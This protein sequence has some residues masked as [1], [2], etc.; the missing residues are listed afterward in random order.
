M[1]A[2]KAIVF[3]LGL[4]VPCAALAAPVEGRL[5]TGGAPLTWE[6]LTERALE[7]RIVYVGEEH[8]NRSHHL[9]QRDLL[10]VLADAGPVVLGVEYF[11]R[12][13]QPVLDRFHRGEIPLD[14]FPR[15]VDWKKTWGHAWDAY[16]PL[17]RL[18]HERKIRIVALNSKREVVRRIRRGGIES[19]ELSDLLD[20]PRL[21][22]QVEAHRKRV[23]KQ[24]QKVHPM[25]AEMLERYYEG[26]TVW[27]ETMADTTCETFL[28]DRRADLRMLVVA[29]R[30]HVA[31]G[32][33]IPDRVSRRLDLPRL[34]V[35]GDSQGTAPTHYADVILSPNPKRRWY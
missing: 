7:A 26:F 3:S 28:R 6:Q 8:G 5:R 11:P 18:C 23:L 19:L 34:T 31:D 13:L 27:D 14:E 2:S 9:L 30:A 16:E 12:S 1:R 22:L 21:D 29:G 15:A 35:L 17:F 20:L 33:G 24:L 32:T 4:L 25:P 10:A